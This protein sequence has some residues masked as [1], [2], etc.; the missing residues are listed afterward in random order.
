M[1]QVPKLRPPSPHSSRCSSDF[2]LRHREAT[3][4]IP[5]T[6]ANRTMKMTSSIH[7]TSMSALPLRGPAVDED[8]QH[9]ADRTQA[10]WYHQKNGIPNSSGLSV[11]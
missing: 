5:E 6:S 3:K 11:L 8:R 2:A 4:P 9:R 10:I 1:I 7:L